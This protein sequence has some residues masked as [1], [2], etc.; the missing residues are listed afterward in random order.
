M[1]ISRDKYLIL[2]VICSL[3]LIGISFV[4]FFDHDDDD[5]KFGIV[6]SVRETTS[7]Y[8]FEIVDDS[9]T[10]YSCFFKEKPEIN[11]VYEMKGI[12]D[13]TDSMVFIES[14]KKCQTS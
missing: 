4:D 11:S 3:I 2:S 12:F 14:L 8:V 5:I 1:E 10:V 6:V 7:G 9:N 13:G